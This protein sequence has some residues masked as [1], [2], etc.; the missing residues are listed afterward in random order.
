MTTLEAVRPATRR[1]ARRGRGYFG[2]AIWHPKSEINIGTLWRHAFLY[3][4]AFVATIGRRYQKQAS[5]TPGTPNHVPLLHYADLDDLLEHLPH[6][7]PLVG[8]E[9][10]EGSKPLPR[11][12]HPPRALYLLG[13]EDHGL[14]QAILQRCH[15]VVQI[16]TAR[17]WSMNVSVAGSILMYDRMV[18]S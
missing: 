3:D 10:A 1:T 7:C 18:K 15:Q 11:F 4:A 9:L 5:D 14:P 8:V 2:I 16:P 12:S 17:E 13:A 6:S